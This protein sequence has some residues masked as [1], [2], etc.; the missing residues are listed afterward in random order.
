MTFA[1]FFFCSKE[2]QLLE[3]LF[4]KYPNLCVDLTPGGEMYVAFEA[5]YDYYKEFFYK[6]S[7]RVIF[8]TD[9]SYMA[10]KKYAKWQFDV[11]TTYL[12]TD[13]TILSFDDKELK[14]LGLTQDKVDNIF[15]ANFEQRAG[16]VP[17]PMNKEKFKA[18]IEKYSFAL[19][20]EDKERIKPLIEK[21]L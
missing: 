4:K 16:K 20:D 6:Y 21:Y 9:Y 2:P 14:G 18:Y 19:T 7:D 17:K 3:E 1:H 11:T 12:G 5:N 10:D 8:G 13:K 15:F